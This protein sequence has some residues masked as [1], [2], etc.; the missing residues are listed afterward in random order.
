[1]LHFTT[2]VARERLALV[3]LGEPAAVRAYY[4]L[5]GRRLFDEWPGHDQ[6]YTELLWYLELCEAVGW[7]LTLGNA[8]SWLIHCASDRCGVCGAAV[9]I[10]RGELGS[11]QRAS[12]VT[13]GFEVRLCMGHQIQLHQ[14]LRERKSCA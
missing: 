10:K 9:P 6:H 12:L 1:M 14:K 5:A 11:V 3:M 8:A 13:V 2:A 4:A 7:K